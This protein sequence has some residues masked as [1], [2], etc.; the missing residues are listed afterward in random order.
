M[1][2]LAQRSG[3]SKQTIIDIEAGRA[4][5][6]IDTLESIA[7]AL[8][9]SVRALLTEMGEDVL[10]QP[11]ERAVWQEEG[12]VTVRQLDQVFGSGYVQ[13]SVL[14]LDQ[15]SGAGRPRSGSR[16]MLRHC[17]VLEGRVRLGPEKSAVDVGAGDFVRFSGEGP[18]VFLPITPTALVH[19]VTTTPQLSMR[20][21]AAKL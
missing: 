20:S 15:S 9:T 18:H 4:N 5:P 14:R 13:N 3:L 11:K 2:A 6:T 8:G 7:A 10:V 17:Y 21:T 19:V 16:G 1:H 12:P